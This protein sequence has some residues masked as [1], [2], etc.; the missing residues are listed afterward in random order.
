MRRRRK[1]NK[2]ALLITLLLVEVKAQRGIRLFD[3]LSIQA[4]SSVLLSLLLLGTIYGFGLF[5]SARFSKR[6]WFAA[7]PIG[8]ILFVTIIF[9]V[10]VITGF[11]WLSVLVSWSLCGLITL[12]IKTRVKIPRLFIIFFILFS[13]L[14]IGAYYS[15]FHYGEGGNIYGIPVDFAFHNGV[16]TSIAGGGNFPPQYPI[17]SSEPLRYYYFTDLFIAV[18]VSLGLDPIYS[19]YLV[20]SIGAA[21]L[22]SLVFVVGKKLG[23]IEAG[24]MALILLLFSSSLFYIP[25][26]NEIN[27]E[28]FKINPADYFDRGF[29]FDNLFIETFI[30]QRNFVFPIALLLVLVL[31][32]LERAFVKNYF[33]PILGSAV[34]LS[35]GWHPFVA[36]TALLLLLSTWIIFTKKTVRSFLFLVIPIVA[37]SVPFLFFFF[38]KATTTPAV[39]FDLDIGFLSVD[40]SPLG[41]ILFW[42]QNTG[43]LLVPAIIYLF[44]KGSGSERLIFASALPAFILINLFS[45]FHFKWDG[46]KFIIPLFYLSVIFTAVFYARLI[47]LR[48]E[49]WFAIVPVLF[50]TSLGGTIFLY[51]YFSQAQ[52]PFFDEY[53]LRGCE[54]ISNEVPVNATLLTNNAYT[55][56]YGLVGRKVFL[57]EKFWIETH[58]FNYSQAKEER[59]AMLGGNCSLIKKH[60]ITH[61]YTGGIE[62]DIF[63]INQSFLITNAKLLYQEKHVKLYELHC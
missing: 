29:A 34:G 17:F 50:L 3:F 2:R 4:I 56:A 25:Y 61:L 49:F 23:G 60:A 26:W 35:F 1:I 7:F 31:F 37:F 62:G 63:A 5:V 8:A 46:I 24:G 41:I 42:L 48:K 16:V 12:R 59:D 43:F 9:V 10:S 52:I 45:L 18:F 14:L 54:F 33:Y 47:K 15:F 30:L 20:L 36:V 11:S 28:N 53:D 44:W 57:G 19:T 40:K 38:S 13:I 27:S 6:P 32:I 58:G 22:F 55:C 51:S 21:A 39:T